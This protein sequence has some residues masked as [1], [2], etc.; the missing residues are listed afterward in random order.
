MDV[1][2]VRQH[3]NTITAQVDDWRNGLV[4]SPDD[5]YNLMEIIGREAQQALDALDTEH[6]AWV[7]ND[8]GTHTDV[9]VIEDYVD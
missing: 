2:K 7:E 5:R 4:A 1:N 6:T 9:D 3:L 8:D